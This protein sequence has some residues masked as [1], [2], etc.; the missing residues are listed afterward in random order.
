MKGRQFDIF[1]S[2]GQATSTALTILIT[3]DELAA[4]ITYDMRRRLRKAYA[5][6]CPDEMDI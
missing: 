3:E 1:R 6:Y 2:V 5:T 4:E